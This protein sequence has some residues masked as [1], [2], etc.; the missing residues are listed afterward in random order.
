MEDRSRLNARAF[1]SWRVRISTTDGGLVTQSDHARQ[2]AAFSVDAT[3]GTSM[4]SA[5]RTPRNPQGCGPARSALRM[6]CWR[7]TRSVI[8]RADSLACALVLGSHLRRSRN[9]RVLGPPAR[10]SLQDRAQRVPVLREGVLNA[11]G[12]FREDF[13]T[14][15]SMLLQRAESLGQCLR[16]DPGE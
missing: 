13:S 10:Q 1:P 4:P 8:K 12:N 14:D 3:A 7:S 5:K 15:N 9:S 6:R 11:R 2:P 16:A